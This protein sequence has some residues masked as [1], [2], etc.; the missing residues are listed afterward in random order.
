MT[1]ELISLAKQFRL[2]VLAGG[3]FTA[4]E[5]LS[6]EEYLLHLLRAE[7]TAREERAKSH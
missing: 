6:G 5:A 1:P 7:R 2:S 4:N 3:K